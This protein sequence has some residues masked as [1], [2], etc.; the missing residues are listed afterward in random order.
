MQFRKAF[1]P[2]LLM[3]IFAAASANGAEALKIGFVAPLNGSFAPIGKQMQAGTQSAA[4]K[5]SLIL[6][7][8]D[9]VCTPEGGETAARALVAQ[10]V[11][12]VT[13]FTCIESLNAALPILRD[14]N[15]ITITTGVRA[16]VLTDNKPKTGFLL[17]RLAPREDMEVAALVSTLLPRWRAKNFAIIDDGTVQARNTA[18]SLRLAATEANLQPVFNDTFRPGLENQVALVRR[19]QKAGA[20]HVFIGGDISDAMIIAQAASQIASG[21]DVIEIALGE[22]PDPENGNAAK[23][24]IFS[25]T[26]PDYKL[27][28]AATQASIALQTKGIEPDNYALSAY[29]AIEIAANVAISTPDFA[30]AL[31]GGNF[32]TA[33]GKVAFDDKGDLKVNPF[34]LEQNDF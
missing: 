5:L 1:V 24:V 28:S 33:I 26:L 25:I 11:D 3:N 12:I 21:E 10:K 7:E 17:Y 34:S 4:Q 30:K 22:S 2:F 31:S 15:I 9:E 16:D 18:Q 8:Q 19:L 29:A 23:G 32:E 6:V 14:A 13:G 20:T 27:L